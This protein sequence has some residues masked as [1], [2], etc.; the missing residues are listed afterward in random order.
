MT[1]IEVVGEKGETTYVLTDE[2]GKTESYISSITNN[3]LELNLNGALSLFIYL[4]I[5]PEIW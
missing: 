3:N 1:S 4:L 5:D 2:N